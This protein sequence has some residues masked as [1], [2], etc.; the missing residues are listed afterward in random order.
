MLIFS[1]ELI[2]LAVNTDCPAADAFLCAY[3]N[4]ATDADIHAQNFV[5]YLVSIGSVTPEDRDNLLG[6]GGLS[7][8]PLVDQM[9][10]AE[11]A[12]DE[13]PD[14]SNDTEVPLDEGM[15]DDED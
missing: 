14:N 13:L 6:L 1:D 12:I 2:E 10:D 15:L 11:H 3:E 5:N 9:A 4:S 8:N 7:D